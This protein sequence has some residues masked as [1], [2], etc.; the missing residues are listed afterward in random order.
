M[1]AVNS[2]DSLD[3]NAVVLSKAEPSLVVRQT[4]ILG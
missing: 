2:D 1:L 3:V 4:L